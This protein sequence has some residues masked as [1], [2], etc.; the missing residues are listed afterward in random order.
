VP[1]TTETFPNILLPC[2]SCL[3]KF[4]DHEFGSLGFW[5]AVEPERRPVRFWE[6][7]AQ[8]RLDYEVGKAARPGRHARAAVPAVT[9]TNPPVRTQP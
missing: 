6:A 2:M 5:E 4:L 9:T 8:A 1:E 7:L 3:R